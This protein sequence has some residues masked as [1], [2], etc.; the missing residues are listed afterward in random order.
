L[1]NATTDHKNS[2][3]LKAKL[4]LDP[5]SDILKENLLKPVGSVL[6]WTTPLVVKEKNDKADETTEETIYRCFIKY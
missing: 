2:D 3:I 4:L 5:Y 6:F 1:S